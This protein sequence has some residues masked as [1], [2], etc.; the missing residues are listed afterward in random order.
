MA[1]WTGRDQAA[2][3]HHVNELGALGV[4]P[5]IATPLF[6]QM[7]PALLSIADAIDVLGDGTACELSRR[8]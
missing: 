4:P 8:S 1:G 7:E 3:Q 5:P 6:Y 2:V